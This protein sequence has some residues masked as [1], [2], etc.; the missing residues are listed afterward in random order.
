MRR[1]S[2]FSAFRASFGWH[3][4]QFLSELLSMAVI[5]GLFVVL[6]RVLRA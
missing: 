2:Q 1:L 4:G 5:S 3:F 6:V